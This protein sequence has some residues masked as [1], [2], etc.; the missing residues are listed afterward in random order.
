MTTQLRHLELIFPA[1]VT[2]GDLDILAAATYDEPGRA[3][4]GAA[5][6]EQGN[7]SGSRVYSGNGGAFIGVIGYGQ[8]EPP[9]NFSYWLEDDS[10]RPLGEGPGER[11]FSPIGENLPAEEGT[12]VS[13]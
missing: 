11:A 1:N 12:D 5:R 7:G 6:V 13:R 2:P 3:R 4:L 8:P 9:L 10:P